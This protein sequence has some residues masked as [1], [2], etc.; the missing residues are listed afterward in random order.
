MKS[1]VFNGIQYR[2]LKEFCLMFNLSYSKARR[3]CRHYI[4]A[5]KDPVVA[6]KWLLGI[7]KR[8]YS[9]PKTQ[10]YFHDLELSEDR[11]RDFIEKQRNTFL[12][13]F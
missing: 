1:F 3:L 12:N 13:Y 8:S 5:N 11:Q 10:M 6:I 7:E 4:R 9:E 2:S